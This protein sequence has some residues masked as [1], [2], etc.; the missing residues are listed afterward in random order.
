M[1]NTEC[2]ALT[3]PCGCG[4]IVRYWHAG[5]CDG[6]CGIEDDDE[7]PMSSPTTRSIGGHEIAPTIVGHPPQ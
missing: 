1:P 3:C 6:S 4:N 5:Q 7:T 2:A